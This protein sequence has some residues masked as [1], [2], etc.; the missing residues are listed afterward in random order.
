MIGP[1]DWEQ[2]GRQVGPTMDAQSAIVVVGADPVT[3]A[4]VALGIGRMQGSRRRVAIADL[5]G[6]SPPL[7]SLVHADDPHGI[8][9]SFMYGVSL[10]RIAY[11]VEDA[12]ELFVMPSGTEP[13]DYEDLFLNP[14][15]RRL[16][17]GFREVGALLILAAPANAP[18]LRQLVDATDGAVL[19]GDEVPGELPVSQALAW[20]RPRRHAPIAIAEP[21]YETPTEP[22]PTTY[23]RTPIEVNLVPSPV[24]APPRRRMAPG[25]FGVLITLLLVLTGFWFARRPFASDGKRW[26]GVKPGTPAAAKATGG[27]LQLDSATR[28]QQAAR[29]SAMRDSAARA[30]A[31]AVLPDSFPVLAPANPTDSATASAFAVILENTNGLPGAIVDI[32][33][34]FKH[35]PAGSYSLDLRTRYYKLVAGAYQTRAGADSLL[36]ELRSRKVLAVGFGT[37]AFLPYAFLVDTNVAADDVGPRLA[38]AA[39]RAQPV[40]ALRQANGTVNFY[41]GAYESP[42][43][44]SLAVPAARRA[45]LAPTLVYRTG[46][47]F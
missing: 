21:A 33:G 47:V 38:R 28:A 46:R 7:Q 44:A 10:N 4:Q 24:A 22:T 17:A 6:E 35:V 41:F 19:V 13:I 23:R 14:R 36:T 37:V 32:T 12:G 40:Y 1:T 26:L 34:K 2:E 16:A 39:A 29:D 18:H 5:L 43:E 25:V 8:V 31:L 30:A 11:P 9:D 15:W 42:Q 27:T 3:T 20:V 45:G